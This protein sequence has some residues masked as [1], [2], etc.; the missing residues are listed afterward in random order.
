M[1]RSE[2]ERA[3]EERAEKERALAANAAFYAA[4]STSNLAAMD[5][6]W[7][8]TRDV[9][10][11]HPNWQGIKGRDAVMRSW[12]TILNGAEMADIRPVGAHV[13]LSGKMAMVICEEDLVAIRMIATNIFMNEG[14]TWRIVHHQAT[15]LPEAVPNPTENKGQ[16]GQPSSG[17]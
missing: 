16:K 6:L 1:A 17:R 13:I 4:F 12:A 14:G 3:E 7:S 15:R 9:A 2:K 8:T 10:V 11:F 5:A